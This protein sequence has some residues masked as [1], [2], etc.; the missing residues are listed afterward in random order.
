[1][2]KNRGVETADR[3][4][5]KA[6]GARRCTAHRRERRQRAGRTGVSLAGRGAGFRRCRQGRLR[7]RLHPG[8]AGIISA[9]VFTRP[10]A[11]RSMSIATSGGQP[12]RS[13]RMR[14]ARRRSFSLS[15]T[16]L[17]IWPRTAC[18]PQR[19]QGRDHVE[20]GLLVLAA[21]RRVDPAM[22]S[23]GVFNKMG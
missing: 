17:T 22:I 5:G 18:P 3:L 9:A 6:L 7:R 23:G 4:T 11:F 14:C 8:R 13:C 21:P 10:S 19:D 16:R 15:A 20:G 12:V 2:E 1:M